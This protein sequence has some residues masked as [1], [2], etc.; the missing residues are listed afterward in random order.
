ME[1]A[2]AESKQLNQTPMRPLSMLVSDDNDVA[3]TSA[4]NDNKS[5]LVQVGQTFNLT[6]A[7]K[8]AY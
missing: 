4:G 1:P 8:H 2:R 3:V 5:L 6:T 7:V